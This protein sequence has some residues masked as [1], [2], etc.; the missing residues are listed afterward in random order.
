MGFGHIGEPFAGE[1]KLGRVSLC[2]Y[3][4]KKRDCGVRS[5]NLSE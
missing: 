5:E 3:L 1:G 2:I 4:D